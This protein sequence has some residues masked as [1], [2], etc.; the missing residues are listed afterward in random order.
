MRL[1]DSTPLQWD[2]KSLKQQ[3]IPVDIDNILKPTRRKIPS[4]NE[5]RSGV[6]N[7]PHRC[8]QLDPGQPTTCKHADNNFVYRLRAQNNTA[9]HEKNVKLRM[10]VRRVKAT[11]RTVAQP[12]AFC[13]AT[14]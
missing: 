3:L 5:S 13:A 9:T 4:T 12:V 11:R 14:S 10:D 1:W 2:G 6:S 7:F 8:V